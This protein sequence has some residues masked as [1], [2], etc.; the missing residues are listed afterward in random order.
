VN[1]GWING[2]MGDA[3][4][5]AAF[6]AVIMPIAINFEPELVIISAGFDAAMGDPLGGCCVTPSGYAHMTSMLKTLAKGRVLVVLEGGYNLRSLAY[7]TEACVRVLMGE[8]DMPP[9]SSVEPSCV[10]LA[11]ISR[12]IQAQAP[13]WRC[14][15]LAR[16]FYG[17]TKR[18]PMHNMSALSTLQPR[19]RPRMEEEE[20]EKR[21]VIQEEQQQE[22]MVSPS[23]RPMKLETIGLFCEDG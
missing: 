16:H 5:L 9:A 8:D 15:R 14:L 17:S 21:V 20:E 2:G 22:K 23:I 12:T 1:I 6:Y 4:Y 13:Y 19:K 7:S 3:E 18:S 10:G 11:C